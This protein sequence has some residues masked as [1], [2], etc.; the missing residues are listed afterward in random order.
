MSSQRWVGWLPHILLVDDDEAVGESL[1]DLLRRNRFTV[2]WA[3]N[4]LQA[5]HRAKARPPAAIVLDVGLPILDGFEFIDE[6]RSVTVAHAPIVIVS[7]IPDLP[8]RAKAVSAAG[9]LSKPIDHQYLLSEVKR[10]TVERSTP[11]PVSP[12]SGGTVAP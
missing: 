2:D 4:G 5:L 9:F 3:M 11:P 12:A 6:Y 10:L 8:A 7:A 1:S